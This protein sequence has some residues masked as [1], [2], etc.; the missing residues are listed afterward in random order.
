MSILGGGILADKFAWASERLNKENTA[1]NRVVLFYASMNMI[2]EKPFL[3]WGYENFNRYKNTFIDRSIVKL[4]TAEASSITSHNTY[5]TMMVEL[6]LIAFFLY[7][8]PLIWWLR[9]TLK[10]FPHLPR[11]GVQ[12]RSLLVV[13]WLIILAYIITANFADQR[14]SFYGVGLWWLTLGLAASYITQHL[15]SN[16]PERLSNSRAVARLKI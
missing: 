7:T 12:G 1:K 4:N 5:L 11:G 10:I 15:P 3:G 13:Y 9:L 6:G 8:I 14:F 2:E 16:Q